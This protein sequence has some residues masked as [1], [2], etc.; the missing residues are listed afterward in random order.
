MLLKQLYYMY[1]NIKPKSP[2]KG[3]A[4][5]CFHPLIKVDFWSFQIHVVKPLDMFILWFSHS[6]EPPLNGLTIWKF[7]SL[8]NIPKLKENYKIHY[9]MNFVEFL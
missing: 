6:I 8:V 9:N 7:A 4:I 1:Y 5:M 3:V 2:P